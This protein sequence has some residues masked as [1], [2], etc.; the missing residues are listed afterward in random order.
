MQVGTEGAT[1]LDRK[2]ETLFT[3]DNLDCHQYGKPRARYVFLKTGQELTLS[4]RLARNGIIPNFGG[5]VHYAPV[6]D[7]PP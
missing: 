6:D 4:I 5:W 2:P 7:L 3:V 1:V